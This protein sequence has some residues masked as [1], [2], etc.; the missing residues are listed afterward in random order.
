MQ[1]IAL[2]LS[3]NGSG[4]H[5][6]Q[7]QKNAET[8]C[9]TLTQAI[10]KTLGHR[11]VLHGCGRTDTGVHAKKYMANFKSGTRIPLER[12]PYAI[13]SRLPSDIVIT[14]AWPVSESFNSIGS[15]KEKEYTYYL[16]Q[17]PHNDP[18]LH[19]RALR[20]PFPLD[21]AK[22][23]KAAQ[24]FTGTHD[25]ACVRT[26]GTPV[27]STVRTLIGFDISQNH[28]GLWAFRMRANG[29]LY[30]MARALVGT[31]LYVNEGKIGDIPQLI[32]STDRSRAGP[33]VP[34]CGLYMT[35]AEYGEILW[36]EM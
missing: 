9:G 3:F 17:T 19:E 13:N 22:M 25:F 35:D 30:N 31:V 23:Q 34:A 5:G 26:Q 7:I 12:I 32:A 14:Q 8:V 15:C 28:E 18:F 36:N 33:V 20:Y 29:F 2:G 21:L 11:V 4:Y 24:D 27:K 6:W 10:E 16:Y 1:N